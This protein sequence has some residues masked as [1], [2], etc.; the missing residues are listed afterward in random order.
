MINRKTLWQASPSPLGL[1]VL[2]LFMVSPALAQ[3]LKNEGSTAKRAE[4]LNNR[5]VRDPVAANPVVLA[6]PTLDAVPNFLDDL[7]T[8]LMSDE[9]VGQLEDRYSMKLRSYSLQYGFIHHQRD[10]RA[11]RTYF[12]TGAEEE[13]VR[14]EMAA[15]I[16]HYMLVRGLPKFLTS[17]E[18]TR[19]IGEN[20]TKAVTLAQNVARVD[21]KGEKSDWAF[22]AG[23][24]PFSTKAWA[25]YSNK[26]STIEA[27]NFFN[28]ENTLAVI[29]YTR[30][31]KYVPRM[32]Y[33]IQKKAIEPGVKYIASARFD[34]DF[35]TYIPLD[36]PSPSFYAVNY[37]TAYYRF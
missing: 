31:K 22:N 29:A 37:I 25:K 23:L 15:S 2:C 13:Q 14:A 9:L 5:E 20:Y 17:K 34:G 33:H 7:D 12:G 21:F 6:H 30:V 26:A 24:N 27:Y 36:S 8:H 3:T 18:S 28:Q 10:T 16:K 32:Q 4:A 35:R 1:D 19:Y 11:V